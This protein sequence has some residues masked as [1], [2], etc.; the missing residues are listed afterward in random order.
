MNDLNGAPDTLAARF[1]PNSAVDWSNSG[2][3]LSME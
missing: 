1:D 3:A 2:A